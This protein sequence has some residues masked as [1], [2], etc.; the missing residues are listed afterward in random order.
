MVDY[1]HGL[2]AILAS[3]ANIHDRLRQLEEV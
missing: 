1:G 2:A 3:Q